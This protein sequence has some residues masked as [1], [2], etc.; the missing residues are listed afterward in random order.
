MLWKEEV[1]RGVKCGVGGEKVLMC[2]MG[3]LVVVDGKWVGVDVIMV[4]DRIGNGIGF[5]GGGVMGGV[6]V[7]SRGVGL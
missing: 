7:E 1:V 5:R 4:W 6:I 3:I 2:D